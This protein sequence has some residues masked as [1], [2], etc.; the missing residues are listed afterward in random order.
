MAD[1]QVSDLPLIN[2]IT[3]DD[4]LIVNDGNVT[5]SV[6]SWA[7]A[8]GSITRLRGQVLFDNGVEQLP[9]ISF[10][11]DISTGIYNPN[12]NEIAFVTNSIQRGVFDVSGRFGIANYTPADY[13]EGANNLVIGDIDLGDNGM[14]FVSSP[15][16]AGIINFADGTDAQEA[17]EGQILYDHLD[18]HMGFSVGGSESMRINF[19]GDVQIGTTTNQFGSLL[20]ADGTITAHRGT[21]TIPGFNFFGDGDTG[22]YS[23]G[24]DQVTIATG[25]ISQLFIDAEGQ[26][27]I[28]IQDAQASIHINRPTPTIRIEDSDAP[29]SPYA[30]ISTV[31]G[32]IILDSDLAELADNSTVQVR[33]DNEEQLRINSDGQTFIRSDIYFN[34]PADELTGAYAAI[35]HTPSTGSLVVDSDPYANYADST[36]DIRVD[37]VT[38][39]LIEDNGNVN[40]AADG[41]LTFAGDDDTYF[42]HPTTN[43][44]GIY[45][46]GQERL[47]FGDQGHLMIGAATPRFI[48]QA[49]PGLQVS[50]NNTN[51]SSSSFSIYSADTI[52]TGV[53]LGKSRSTSIG[54]VQSVQVGDQLGFVSFSGADGTSMNGVGASITAVVDDTV[55]T[56]SVPSSLIIRTTS[57]TNT[58]PSDRLKV[59]SNGTVRLLN[60]PSLTGVA[61]GV[62]PSGSETMTVT[63]QGD[64][65]ASG[66]ATVDGK[67]YAGDY[68]IEGLPDLP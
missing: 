19:E 55:D 24:A 62:G 9:S 52:G 22:I 64:L 31:N 14:T 46:A 25:G 29:L 40:L 32:D 17:A 50:G 28:G 26:I 18:N 20:T 36:L 42:Y 16:G 59:E 7:D 2:T 49:S 13:N 15:T 6:I 68:D 66:D 8:L 57:E 51:A 45:T 21:S 65:T 44:L 38:K 4:M 60:T 23:P 5:T 30:E 12:L 53:F 58:S 27:G 1:V 34:T 41:H 43:Q 33:V 67:V 54:G 56:L 37:G 3:E 48:A 61:L 35:S 10:V 11:N 39:V 47:R 63:T